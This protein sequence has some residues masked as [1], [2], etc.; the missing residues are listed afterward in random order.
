MY[1]Y[2][3]NH[4]IVDCVYILEPKKKK[5]S[6]KHKIYYTL[7]EIYVNKYNQSTQSDDDK[8]NVAIYLQKFC[9]S[10]CLECPSW[11]EPD[12]DSTILDNLNPD[13]QGLYNL[14]NSFKKYRL[15]DF[16]DLGDVSMLNRKRKRKYLKL[17]IWWI[18]FEELKRQLE[19]LIKKHEREI[20]WMEKREV[21]NMYNKNIICYDIMRTICEFI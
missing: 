8:Y 15:F 10:I 16:Q 9:K 13:L 18:K 17:D 3:E 21:I 1:F 12:N 5:I 6:L 14:F 4:E 7:C 19:E 20:K 11:S 2:G